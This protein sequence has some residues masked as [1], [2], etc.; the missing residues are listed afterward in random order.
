MGPLFTIIIIHF[1]LERQSIIGGA[2]SSC[3][4][5]GRDFIKQCGMPRLSLIPLRRGGTWW[6]DQA[7]VEPHLPRGYL[8]VRYDQVV[9]YRVKSNLHMASRYIKIINYDYAASA[10]SQAS[11]ALPTIENSRWAECWNGNNCWGDLRGPAE[12]VCGW[13]ANLQAAP[14]CPLLLGPCIVG[15]QTM[16]G[17][18]VSPSIHH[19]LW[20]QA[21][22]AV[23]STTLQNW[24]VVHHIP[25]CMPKQEAWSRWVFERHLW[26][27]WKVQCVCVWVNYQHTPDRLRKVETLQL[28][29]EILRLASRMN[30]WILSLCSLPC[31]ISLPLCHEL[32][33][34]MHGV[35]EES[36]SW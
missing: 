10:C 17:W 28:C 26:L 29:Y 5:S 11:K 6:S 25:C 22:P 12:T 8:L 31:L 7:I 34:N 35:Q 14:L 33:Q 1:I 4:E 36:S 20:V 3:K 23:R 24:T 13:S 15:R 27:S 19:F 32:R 2:T 16:Q 18:F 21:Q 9:R 30:C